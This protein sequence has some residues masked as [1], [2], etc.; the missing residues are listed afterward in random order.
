MMKYLFTMKATMATVREVARVCGV[1][2]MT[3]SFVLNNKRDQVSEETRERVLKTIRELGYRPRAVERRH[4]VPTVLTLGL[5]TGVTSESLVTSG[6]YSDLLRELVMAADTLGHNLTVFTNRLFRADTHD[7]IRVYC[8]GR[9]DGLLL[10]A[11]NVGNPVVPALR[12]RGVPFV[13]VGDTGEDAAMPCADVANI[14]AGEQAT[15]YLLAQG[16]RRIAFVGG[17]DLVR[18]ALQRQQGF[19]QALTDVG[20]SARDE[21]VIQDIIYPEVQA[22]RLHKIMATEEVRPTAVFCWNDGA[23]RQAIGTLREM[24]LRVP[25]DISVIGFD[26]EAFVAADLRLTTFRQPYHE[27]ALRAI[28]I[29]A[30]QVRGEKAS[31]HRALLPATLV[32]RATVGPPPG[33]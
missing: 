28:E 3:V 20:L 31:E 13:L 14:A 10:I 29:L 22:K 11:P 32:V 23:A 12:E 17:P 4:A 2:P 18:S 6:Y 21:W 1:S 16:H 19:R 15:A 24:G 9:C 7:S 30:G 8:D 5:V 33:F 27:I 26:D 25:E